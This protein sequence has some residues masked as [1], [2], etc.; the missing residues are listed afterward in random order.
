MD[1]Q[2]FQDLEELFGTAGWRR[3]VRD[4]EEAIRDRE[5][6]ALHARSYDEVCFLRGEATQLATLVSLEAS[7][8]TL[9]AQL[10]RDD[11]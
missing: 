11:E 8:A 1:N 7:I 6:N 9:R 3:I 4:A 5:A 2:Y 10:D